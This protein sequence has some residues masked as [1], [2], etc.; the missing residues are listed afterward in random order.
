MPILFP[1]LKDP[2]DTTE[3]RKALLSIVDEIS[4]GDITNV[5]NNNAKGTKRIILS[6]NTTDATN[7]IDFAAGQVYADDNETLLVGSASTKRL[8]ATFTA[9]TGGGG[10]DTGSKANSTWYSCWIIGKTDGTTDYL[11]S[12][13]AT[14]P[15]LPSGFTL[16]RRIMWAYVQSGGAI[17]PFTQYQNVVEYKV[18]RNMQAHGAIAVTTRLTIDSGAAPNTQARLS[19][20][21][22][23][24]SGSAFGWFMPTTF[25]DAVPSDGLSTNIYT[26][27]QT[28]SEHNILTDASRLIAYRVSSAGVSFTLNCLG[29]TDLEI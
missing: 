15:T 3:L 6:N 20:R 4:S 2:D 19:I 12:T 21:T 16:K 14:S 23:T 27:A 18:I 17:L 5:T 22:S 1:V 11:F 7:D 10:L 25:T 9:G 13:S 26:T 24:P 29:F 8:D 28:Q